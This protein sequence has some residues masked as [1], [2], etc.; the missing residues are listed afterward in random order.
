VLVLV[1]KMS[2]STSAIGVVAGVALASVA[3]PYIRPLLFAAPPRDP[4]VLA[5][6]VVVLLTVAF[7]AGSIPAV[8]INRHPPADA[9]RAD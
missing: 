9:L 7:F 3:S 1:I 6:V 5:T 8:R 4:V 2:L